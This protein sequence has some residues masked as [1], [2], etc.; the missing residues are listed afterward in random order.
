M[1]NPSSRLTKFRLI[2]E[3]YDFTI[4][5]IPGKSNVADALSRVEIPASDLKEL[6][7]STHSKMCI[8]TRARTK[9]QNDLANK[10]KNPTTNDSVTDTR[11]GHPGVVELLKKPKNITELR[12]VATKEFLK[13]THEN[14]N[15]F[16]IFNDFIIDA[17][18]QII[19]YKMDDTYSTSELRSALKDLQ[20]ICKKHNISELLIIKKTCALNKINEIL[21][22]SYI[23]T[24]DNIKLTII[25]DVRTIDNYEIKQ[26]ILNDFHLLHTGGHAGVNRM[27]NN[28]KKFYYWKGLF[29]DIQSF[30]RRC[31]QCQRY[32]HS[33]PKIQP[34]TLTTT[35]STAFEKI[36]LDLMGP[37]DPDM[38][39]NKYVLTIQCDLSK[40][41]EAYPIKNKETVTVANSLVNNFFL[42]YG[43]PKEI[44]T[45]QGTEFMSLVFND[46][47]K[48]LNISHLNSTA[49]HHQTLGSI[50]N[51]HKHLGAYLRM[52]VSKYNNSWS[53]WLPFWCFFYNT[54]VH[55]ETKYTPFELLFG[56][57]ANLPSN[58]TE[59][60]DPLYSFDNYPLELKFRLQ[61]ASAEAKE[62]LEKS[63]LS[64]K[65]RYDNCKPSI[66][67]VN[68]SIGDLVLI[69][70]DS[71]STKMA[72]IYK[73]PYSVVREDNT[74]ITLSE[75]NDKNKTLVVHKNRVKKYYN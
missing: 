10:I 41:V 38:D 15:N 46:T 24:C 53:S 61:Q 48:I 67:N 12:P 72:E 58:I 44:V 43:I 49:Y 23:L 3:E 50:E 62:N 30:V 34:L 40:F 18:L 60:I 26:L 6:A 55:T 65:V 54:T 13:L 22:L 2:L 36:F 37:L 74:N 42:R 5:Y 51:S 35:A 59:K 32:K 7:N 33:I 47:C 66:S 8:M 70:N 45:D 57:T 1:T 16:M 4:R 56:K 52:Q 27:F 39:D 73:G 11:I 19:Y 63:K 75:V 9:L 64:R 20:K 71:A 17:T 29:R 68:F 25:K 69:K 14:K 31:D 21:K 28:I